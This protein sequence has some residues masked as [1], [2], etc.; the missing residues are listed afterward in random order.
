MII[1]D[2]R[3]DY[4]KG[5]LLE[6]DAGDD[7][8]ALFR[9][10]FDEAVAAKLPDPN[11]MTL[12]TAT[13]AGAV[14]ARIVL[15]KGLDE[16]GFSFFTNFESRKGR[17]LAVNPI[18]ALVF[19]WHDF[20]RQVRIEGTVERVSDA[21]SDAYFAS[22]PRGSKISAWASQQSSVIPDRS[23]MEAAAAR[24]E[25]QYPDDVP[26]PPNWGGYRVVPSMIEFWHGRPSR[27]HDR[28]RYTRTPD[29]GWRRERLSP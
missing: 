19:H 18:A 17:E 20:E 13:P 8:L 5:G 3:Q 10:W 21:E 15:L 28:L 26:R 16:R 25:A 22:R 9:R 12:A 11:A 24:L 14:S 27:Q 2:L 4:V 29:G 23:A 1:A 6:A 7:P